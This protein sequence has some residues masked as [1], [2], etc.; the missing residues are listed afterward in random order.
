MKKLIVGTLLSLISCG[1]F[2]A[3]DVCKDPGVLLS[4]Q[5]YAV[6]AEGWYKD[7]LDKGYIV[8]DSTY[9]NTLV[10]D[11]EKQTSYCEGET[12]F[13][14]GNL[15]PLSARFMYRVEY[16]LSGDYETLEMFEFT[17]ITS[18]TFKLLTS[19]IK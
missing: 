16:R 5:K 15:S 1:A 14:G 8:G 6:P 12:F 3:I 2:A 17:T 11:Y 19:N 7:T 18:P 9:V 4:L 13:V 10:N